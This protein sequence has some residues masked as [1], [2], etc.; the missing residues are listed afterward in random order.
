MKTGNLKLTQEGLRL[1][2]ADLQQMYEFVEQGGFF[3]PEALLLHD[4]TN[5]SPIA[6]SEFEDGQR[7]I[8]DGL[9]RVLVIHL[10]GRPL[11]LDEFI[12]EKMT[13]DMFLGVN[14]KKL[15]VT[16][17]DPRTEMRVADF[18]AFKTEV[19][20]MANQ[21]LDIVKFIQENKKRYCVPR[22]Q[23]WDNITNVAK[24]L[25]VNETVCSGR[26]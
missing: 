4:P 17:F 2:S 22:N 11:R 13:Y 10:F 23:C 21:R 6:I 5:L 19:I 7:Y 1:S 8:R 18:R 25:A 24:Y 3:S 9:H 16:P 15:W 20:N 26:F 14:L 12:I